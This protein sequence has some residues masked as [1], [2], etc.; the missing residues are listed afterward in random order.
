M[1]RGLVYLADHQARHPAERRRREAA[2][3]RTIATTK[4]IIEQ[5]RLTERDRAKAI[6]EQASGDGRKAARH[7]LRMARRF[8]WVL[9]Q[10]RAS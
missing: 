2:K 3:E 8:L 5:I 9:A 7:A 6:A 4:E 10:G 1:Q